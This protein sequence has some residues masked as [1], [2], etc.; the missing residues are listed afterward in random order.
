MVQRR[1]SKISHRQAGFTIVELLIATLVFSTVVLVITF[2]II[3]FSRSYYRGSTTTNL[4]NATRNVIDAVSQA[5]QFSGSDVTSWSQ[6]SSGGEVTA[7]GYCIG[8]TQFDFVVGKQRGGDSLATGQVKHALYSAPSAAGSC[9]AINADTNPNVKDLADPNMRVVKFTIKNLG[10][11]LYTVDL[12]LAYGDADLLCSPKVTTANPNDSGSCSSKS[13]P[14]TYDN[15]LYKGDLTC[16]ITNGSQFC[17]AAEL[18]T[19]VQK[20]VQ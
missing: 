16:K 7:G 1:Q 15:Y 18:S 13:D 12:R 11:N 9:T 17:A 20:R 14:T 8:N 2:G 4:Q 5:I 6:T 3:Q 10:P 19:I